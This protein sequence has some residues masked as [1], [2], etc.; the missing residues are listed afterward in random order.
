MID[1]MDFKEVYQFVCMNTFLMDSQEM[2]R[3]EQEQ[4]NLRAALSPE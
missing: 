2:A 1:A 4:V 3:L